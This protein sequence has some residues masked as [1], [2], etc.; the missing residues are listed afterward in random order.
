M[1][2]DIAQS[3]PLVIE[4]RH[5]AT[6]HLLRQFRYDHLPVYL[7][8]VS[9]PVAELAYKLT[10]KLTDGPELSVGLRKLIEAKDCLVRQAVDDHQAKGE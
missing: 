9:G 1:S 8:R 2:E 10:A 7:Q 6:Q 5:P 4:D 3:V